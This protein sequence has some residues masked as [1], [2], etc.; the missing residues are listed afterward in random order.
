MTLEQW[1]ARSCTGKRAYTA[2]TARW[3][4][5][6]SH[7]GTL[8]G[9]EGGDPLCA[10]TCPFAADHPAGEGDWHVGHALGVEALFE[11]ARLLRERSGNAPGKRL[12]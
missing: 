8:P 6:Q 11:I 1:R 2:K 5:A 7:A 4:S 12:P 10:Y 9:D 3:I